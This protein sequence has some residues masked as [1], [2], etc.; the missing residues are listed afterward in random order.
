MFTRRDGDATGEPEP[1][2][3]DVEYH[4]GE[5]ASCLAARQMLLRNTCRLYAL[6]FTSTRHGTCLVRHTVVGN[7]IIVAVTPCRLLSCYHRRSA[8]M[9]A[10]YIV[11]TMRDVTTPL[12][13][14]ILL[15]T[16]ARSFYHIV[17]PNVNIIHGII[18]L[19]LYYHVIVDDMFRAVCHR[20]PRRLAS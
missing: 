5:T 9:A 8:T 19:S 17:I 20:E 12:V 16:S 10:T 14:F 2:A 13:M 18:G 4:I 15:M 1:P 6:H 7:G 11:T 3:R